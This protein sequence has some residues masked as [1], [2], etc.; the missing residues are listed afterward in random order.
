M[1]ILFVVACSYAK[2][3]VWQLAMNICPSDG[4]IMNYCSDLWYKDVQYGSVS[5][6]LTKDF[7][8]KHVRQEQTDYIAIVR[9]KNKIPDAVKVW[10]F[11]ST[12]SLLSWF[13]FEKRNTVT[14]GGYVYVDILPTAKNL[15]NDPIFFVEGDLIFNYEYGDN[16][17]RIVM[18]C[19]NHT[20]LLSTAMMITP[21]A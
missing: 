20:N 12:S 14:E 4:N 17:V 7:V 3:G 9:H 13:Q 11:K 21:T 2:S 18:Q 10:K 15:S 19:L 16:G 5:E 8:S 6:A 1:Y